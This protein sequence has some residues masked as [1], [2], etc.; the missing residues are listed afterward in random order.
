MNRRL[1][2]V[3]Y[4]KGIGIILVVYGHL[5]SSGYHAGLAISPHFFHFSDSFVYSFHMP[6]FF[7]L[8]GLF[9]EKSCERRGGKS[10]FL[11]KM[12]TLAYPYL[13]WSLLQAS[14]ELF[15]AGHSYRSGSL[16]QLLSIPLLPWAQ[17]WFLYALLLMYLCFLGWKVLKQYAVKGMM[18][19]ALVLFLYP[20]QSEYF[21]LIGFS[22]GFLFFVLGVLLQPYM[23]KIWKMKR[24][25]VCSLS[26]GCVF[27]VSAYAIFAYKIQPVRLPGGEHPLYYLF[28]ALLGIAGSIMGAIFLAKHNVLSFLKILGRYSMPIYLAHM[29]VGVG[30]RIILQAVFH[31][32]NPAL[33]MVLGVCAALVIPVCVS[34]IAMKVHL[35]YLFVWGGVQTERK[36]EI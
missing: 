1:D 21:A 23:E 20:V 14:I 30:V 19:T 22:T 18:L 34:V 4:A 6:L 31:V 12:K 24:V 26:L 2:W 11:E 33:H 28:L 3:D 5:L 36:G 15:F 16:T 25:G 17:F 13:L 35:P 9:A 10:F 27:F 7:F 32:V 29:L 8:A